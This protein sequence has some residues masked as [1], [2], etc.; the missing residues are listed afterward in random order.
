MAKGQFNEMAVVT[1]SV[2]GR[3]SLDKNG[4]Q[5]VYL[6]PLGGRFPEDSNTISGTVA[7]RA[8]LHVGNTY[9]VNITE[10]ETNEYGRQFQFQV[11]DHLKGLSILQTAKEIGKV[12]IVSVKE[13][14]RED[15]KTPETNVE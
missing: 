14:V 1:V 4:L 6:T 15:V 9:L 5:A 11:L 10:G 8:G 12:T 7:E 13:K 3:E 2:F